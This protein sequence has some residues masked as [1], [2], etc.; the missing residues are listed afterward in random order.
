MKVKTVNYLAIC[1]NTKDVLYSLNS[2]NIDVENLMDFITNET[3]DISIY[4]DQMLLLYRNNNLF[5]T[6]LA[7]QDANEVF[8]KNAFDS[9]VVALDKFIKNWTHE[10]V[11]EK[12]D[13]IV[14]AF[15]EFLFQGIILTDQSKELGD[16]MMKRSFENI[17]GIK[18]KKGLA[19]FINKAAKSLRNS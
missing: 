9:F 13:L 2:G 17:N 10:R 6:M 18:M 16:R 19:S 7:A 8:T 3:D 11:A 5:V 15:N 12:Y 4:K 14:L 1:D